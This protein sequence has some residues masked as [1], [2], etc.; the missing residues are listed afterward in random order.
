MKV[1]IQREKHS[2]RESIAVIQECNRRNIYYEFWD[3]LPNL[4]FD[5]IAIGS[6]EFIE[7]EVFGDIPPN[8]IPLW[9]NKRKFIKRRVFS[10]SVS[11]T[12]NLYGEHL[13]AKSS[14]KYKRFD[15]CFLKDVKLKS[16]KDILLLSEV[17]TPINEWRL[18]VING[19][20]VCSA[21]YKG[22]DE[23]AECPVKALPEIPDNWCGT[24]DLMD[25]KEYG[26]ELCECHHPFAV[27][28][29]GETEDNHKYF[30]F[31]VRGFQYLKHIYLSTTLP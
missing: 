12:S 31:L 15:A 13:W 24:I 1:Y 18:Y 21:W 30:D 16:E 7:N 2:S 17:V 5:D 25:T 22:E 8:F 27:G 26:I 10:R 3:S 9:F 20:I 19:R 6:V 23:N 11:E 4:K 14:I 28:W 29:Y